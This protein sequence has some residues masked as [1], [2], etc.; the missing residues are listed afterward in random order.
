M[1]CNVA[2]PLLGHTN[3]MDMGMQRRSRNKKEMIKPWRTIIH[4]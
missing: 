3:R 4:Q 1:T 2:D